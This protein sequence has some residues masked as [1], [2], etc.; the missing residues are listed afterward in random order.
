[1]CVLQPESVI[2]D[3]FY[4]GT[5]RIIIVTPTEILKILVHKNFLFV[6]NDSLNQ[7]ILL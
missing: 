2:D 7:L 4:T 1:M 5:I 6:F 3:K